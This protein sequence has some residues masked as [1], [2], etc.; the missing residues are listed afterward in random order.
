MN[1]TRYILIIIGALIFCF[2]AFYNH[3]PI[4]Y[5]DT[6]TYI[7]SGFE[8]IVP[9][10]RPIFYGLLVRHISLSRSLWLVVLFQGLLISYLIRK[11]LELYLPN[12]DISGLFLF[13]VIFLT[14]FTG[15]SAIV[16]QVIPDVF[17]PVSFLCLIIL[18]RNEIK[19]RSGIII[20]I[21]YIISLSVHLSN[22]FIHI[23][24]LSV[25]M[26]FMLIQRIRKRNLIY[27]A[28]RVILCWSL[29]IGTLLIIP[30]VNYSFSGKYRISEGS[31]VFMINHLY[32]TGILTD[33][34]YK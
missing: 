20:S 24:T 1:L 27:G 11:T 17:T 18:L 33:Y 5:S 3:Y 4:V 28:K 31:H 30:A 2:Y 12:K 15:V 22:L 7:H 14:L 10:D 25:I 29:I 34:L 16:S 13:S 9:N 21:I 26:L 23:A 8:N 19:I 6:G 32:E